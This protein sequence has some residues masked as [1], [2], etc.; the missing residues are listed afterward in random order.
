MTDHNSSPLASN[1]N[2]VKTPDV[3]PTMGFDISPSGFAEGEL[4]SQIHLHSDPDTTE[5]AEK[6]TSFNV[7]DMSALVGLTPTEDAAPLAVSETPDIEES[8]TKFPIYKQSFFKLLVIGGSILTACSLLGM[9]M[10][11]GQKKEVAAVP[12]P[13]A[14]PGTKTTEDFKPDPRFGK[15]NSE[16]AM[17]KQE[18]DIINAAAKQQKDA[19][20]KADKE[21]AE[22]AGTASPVTV[23]S[24]EISEAPKTKPVNNDPI[25]ISNPNPAGDA[26]YKAPTPVIIPKQE[27]V[28]SQP[29]S[30]TK[31]AKNEKLTPAFPIAAS[32]PIAR[33]TKVATVQPSQ[34]V[35]RPTRIAA[36]QP[37]AAPRQNNG[38]ISVS[39]DVA[40]TNAVGVWGGRRTASNNTSGSSASGNTKI[41][42]VNSSSGSS[43]LVGQVIKAKFIT[44]FQVSTNAPNQAV[45]LALTSPL[46]DYS[47]NVLLPTGTQIMAD[48]TA[49][50]NGMLQVTTSKAS[51]NGQLVELPRQSFMIQ[52][53][54]R[55]PLI[56]EQKQFG[57]D[58]VRNR[59][60][61]A[62][63]GGALQAVGKN[64]TQP[65]TQT[66]ATAGGIIQNSNP[67]QN[68]FGAVLDGGFSPVMSDMIE[69]NR[70]AN[71]RLQNTSRIWYVGLDTN[72]LL[73]VAQPF[74]LGN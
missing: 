59:D 16:L 11:G 19:K 45:F 69:R 39:Y 65:Q 5:P 46:F 58:E 15:V 53:T 2:Q 74:N 14:S 47:N 29:K 25:I 23:K 64:L 34:P 35:A 72:V 30:D 24:P 41:A 42:Q 26:S 7:N 37:V 27:S 63:A 43:A 33:P 62:F 20:E 10:F 4:L 50:D 22:K 73:I 57:Q 9:I 67:Q 18:Q 52:T 68:I 61:W 70:Q 48:I 12:T 66:I 3:E 36:A 17:S 8:R 38:V 71:Q 28:S 60:F 44:P 54:G 13:A 49:L 51:V 55:Q 21:A 40:N 31:A 32:L 1:D 56:A 6:S